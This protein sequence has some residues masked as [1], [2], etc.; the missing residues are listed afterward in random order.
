MLDPT[1]LMWLCYDMPHGP[2]TQWVST[3][4]AQPGVYVVYRHVAVLYIGQTQNLLGRFTSHMGYKHF[5]AFGPALDLAW[6]VLPQ[7]DTLTRLRVESALIDLFRPRRHG[8][9]SL[10]AHTFH[11]LV[12]RTLREARLEAGK[13]QRDV[14]GDLNLTQQAYARYEKGAGIPRRHLLKVCTVLGLS[15]QEVLTLYDKDATPVGVEGE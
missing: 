4:P 3:L 14:A 15:A 9:T 13:T 11:P 10:G 6:M 1:A 5:A 7:S 12:A 2:L 8:Q